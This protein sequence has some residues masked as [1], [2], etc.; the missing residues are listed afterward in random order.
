[1]FPHPE[2]REDLLGLSQS[3]LCAYMAEMVGFNPTNTT[4]WMLVYWMITN[5]LIPTFDQK[6]IHLYTFDDIHGEVYT[7]LYHLL[8]DWTEASIREHPHWPI[9]DD[10]IELVLNEG[11]IHISTDSCRISYNKLEFQG[12]ITGKRIY[13]PDS[14]NVLSVFVEGLNVES[15]PILQHLPEGSYIL[16]LRDYRAGH[17]PVHVISNVQSP[18]RTRPN[19]VWSVGMI[20]QSSIA[21]TVFHGPLRRDGFSGL[22]SALKFSLSHIS[23]IKG[24]YRMTAWI[25]SRLA[26]SILSY[27]NVADAI[28]T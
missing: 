12:N 17:Q 15:R 16:Y 4:L 18:T 10:D 28:Q 9:K 7:F 26:V 5:K 19:Q 6:R 3:E 8:S 20:G 1:M 25:K 23:K 22:G 2:A 24:C 14:T 27:T 21:S 11:P 13:H